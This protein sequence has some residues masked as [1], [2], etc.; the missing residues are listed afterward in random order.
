MIASL[1]SIVA[2]LL[3]VL[4]V[5]R[6][7]DRVYYIAANE[8]LWDY[9]PLGVDPNSIGN[10]SSMAMND[11]MGMGSGWDSYA[12]SAPNRYVFFPCFLNSIFFSVLHTPIKFFFKIQN[13]PCLQKG[14][15]S[16]IHRRLLPY[17]EST[18][19]G[20]TVSRVSRARTARARRRLDANPLLQ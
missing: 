8:V 2:A 9:A 10:M 16:R 19:S 1:R 17:I 6:A 4:G 13:W 7:V 12:V 18:A 15:L 11:T 3:V 14:H 5:V 20:A